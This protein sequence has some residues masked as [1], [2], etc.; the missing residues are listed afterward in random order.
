MQLI[1]AAMGRACEGFSRP[2]AR[3][4]SGCSEGDTEC[5]Q[6]LAVTSTSGPTSFRRNVWNRTEFRI[7]WASFLSGFGI[8]TWE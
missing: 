1:P 4:V 6:K 5:S 3:A 8:D 7:A 2:R